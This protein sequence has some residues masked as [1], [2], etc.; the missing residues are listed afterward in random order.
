[1]LVHAF[2]LT[3]AVIL[4]VPPNAGNV[5]RDLFV[6]ATLL[7]CLFLSRFFWDYSGNAVKDLPGFAP[8]F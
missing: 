1:M 3:E 8:L 7:T 5:V 2:L 4:P 6:V